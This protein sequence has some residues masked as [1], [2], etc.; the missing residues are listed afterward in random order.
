MGATRLT[1]GFDYPYV[2]M[3]DPKTVQVEPRFVVRSRAVRRRQ[4]RVGL[5]GRAEHLAL[6]HSA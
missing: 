2:W 4:R 5:G 6:A 3:I 1:S